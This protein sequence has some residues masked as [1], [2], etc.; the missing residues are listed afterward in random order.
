[1]RLVSLCPSVTETVFALGRGADLV[2]VTEWCVHPRDGVAAIEKVGGTKRPDVERIVA[3]APDLVLLNEEEN[4]REDAE[5]L[6]AAGVRCHA[7]LPR[8]PREAAGAVRSLGSVLS[9][10]AAAETLA[11][12]IERRV[13]RLERS[14]GALPRPSYVYLIWRKPWMAAG[15]GT[16]VTGLLEVAGGRNALA[17][18]RERYPEI[19][20]SELATAN[21]L[22]VFLASEPLPFD[23]SHADELARASGLPRERF[24]LVDGELLSWHGARTPAGLDYASGLFPSARSGSG[25]ELV[26]GAAKAPPASPPRSGS[27]Q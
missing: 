2:G 10:R 23:A 1:M 11:R 12:E 25:S 7:S 27:S 14:P 16:Y 17:E 4:R 26:D 5:A 9:R 13:E 18:R 15:E 21:P 20:P 6:V 8:S 22:W 24:R 3:L 19:D